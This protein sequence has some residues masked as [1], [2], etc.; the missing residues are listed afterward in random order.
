MPSLVLVFIAKTEAALAANVASLGW[1]LQELVDAQK[2]AL[3]QIYLERSEIQETGEYVSDCVIDLGHRIT[4]QIA[5]RRLRVV[6][7]RGTQH[8]TN[9]YPFI[10]FSGD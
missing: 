6:K 9:E 1:D 4:D 3:D 5:T 8:G 10:V 7:Y 2:L